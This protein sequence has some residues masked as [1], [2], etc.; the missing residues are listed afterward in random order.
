LCFI[1]G[2]TI[3]VPKEYNIKCH[4]KTHHS[5][6]DQY[7]EKLQEDKLCDFKFARMK[8]QSMF[9]NVHKDSGATVKSSYVIA[10]LL[11]K[12]VKCFSE[13]EFGRQCLVY[14]AEIV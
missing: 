10:Q 14:T 4:Y 11:A 13:S 2:Q 6:Y 1:C 7:R 3:S 12:N 5:K 9:T 8:Q